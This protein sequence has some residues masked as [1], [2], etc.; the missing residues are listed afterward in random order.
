M[1]ME[2]KLLKRKQRT[3]VLQ[4]Q[5]LIQMYLL[6][7]EVSTKKQKT[8]LLEAKT[9]I[10]SLKDA[11]VRSDEKSAKKLEQDQLSIEWATRTEAEKKKNRSREEGATGRSR[12]GQATARG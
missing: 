1:A 11:L 6:A 4:K 2:V 9:C 5:D 7:E 10:S 3:V 8:K 12:E